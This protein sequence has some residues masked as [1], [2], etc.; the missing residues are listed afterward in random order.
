MGPVQDQWNR[1]AR[2]RSRIIAI[3]SKQDTAEFNYLLWTY[4]QNCYAL[5]DWVKHEL[6]I[7]NSVIDQW[8]DL[9]EELR[10]CRA[11]ANGTKHARWKN[12]YPSGIVNLPE[13]FM[14]VQILDDNF[15]IAYPS[16][17]VAESIYD[18][19]LFP[20]NLLPTS[21]GYYVIDRDNGMIFSAVEL[22]NQCYKLWE[23]YLRDNGLIK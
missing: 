21:K 2:W 9:H 12:Q 19:S 8:I 6:S 1:V 18:S 13:K 14:G 17:C 10:L 15:V 4:F 3:E 23:H 7:N 16:T 20:Q 22:V 11:I 5:K